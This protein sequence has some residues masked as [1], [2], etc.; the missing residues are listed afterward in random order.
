MNEIFEAL[1]PE[2]GNEIPARNGPPRPGDVRN[3]WIDASRA[4]DVLGWEAEVGFVDGIR[5]TVQSFQS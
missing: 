4:K 1:N 5:M 3:F 2:P